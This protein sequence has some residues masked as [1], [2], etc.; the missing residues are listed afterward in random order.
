MTGWTEQHYARLAP[1]MPV[2][3]TIVRPDAERLLDA[4]LPL[5]SRLGPWLDLR[6]RC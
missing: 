6:P 1:N 5:L 3:V 4:D 2:I